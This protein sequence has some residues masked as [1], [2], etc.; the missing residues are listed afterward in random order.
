MNGGPTRIQDRPVPWRFRLSVSLLLPATWIVQAWASHNPRI[1]ERGYSRTLYPS[2]RAIIGTLT[3]WFPWSLAEASLVLTGLV[4]TWRAARV[5]IQLAR[6]QRSLRNVI[7]HALSVLLATIG[8]L[9]AW[10]IFGWGMNYQRQPFARSV[11]FDT[12]QPSVEELG[13]LC[14]ELGRSASELRKQLVE[15]AHGVMQPLGSLRQALERA[16]LGVDRAAGDYDLLRDGSASRPKAVTFPILSWLKLGGV[17][18]AYTSETNVNMGPPP[19]SVLSSTC[20]EMA[21]QLGWAREEE[22]SFVGHVVCR[23]HPDADFRYATTQA[24]LGSAL[25]ALSRTDA[26][27]ARA[28]Y[29]AL[30][31]GIQRDWK[32]MNDFWSHYDTGLAVVA[33]KVN[34]LYL[35]SQRQKAGVRSYGLM[36]RLLIAEQR[37]RAEKEALHHGQTLLMRSAPELLLP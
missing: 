8:A 17:F 26:E 20:H 5:P 9:Y 6:R 18:S 34:D 16:P 1:V 36:I 27:A 37:R 30:D 28:V 11:G 15:D 7:A 12:S 35:K 3:G 14:E 33:N 19:A 32:A 10:G 21:H 22:A 13:R 25:T 29:D 23:N 4:L 31:P 2:I 24:A